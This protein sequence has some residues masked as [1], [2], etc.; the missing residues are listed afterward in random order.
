[1]VLLG[2]VQSD[3]IEV[4]VSATIASLPPCKT[5]STHHST[6]KASHNLVSSYWQQIRDRFSLDFMQG[7]ALKRARLLFLYDLLI[8]KLHAIQE[9]DGAVALTSPA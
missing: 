1:M 2:D 7:D 9:M 8:A 5:F 6:G 4:C 3:Q